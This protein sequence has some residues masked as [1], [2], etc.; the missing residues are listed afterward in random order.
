[1]K[2]YLLKDLPGKGKKG[3][4]VELNDGYARNF[5]I[6][7]GIGKAADNAIISQVQSQKQSADFHK[8]QEI[9]VIKKI[10][11]RLEGI[12]LFMCVKTGINGK[13]FGSITGAEIAGELSKHG[14]E[15]DKKSL[16]FEPIKGT[17]EYKIK[18]RFEHG[19]SGQFNL[20]VTEG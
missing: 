12:T 14:F 17:G 5:V 18:V 20:S 13:V 8:A 11:E 9:A 15:I 19:L 1:M 6:K 2:I 7:N 10:C 4:I 16:V 3:E